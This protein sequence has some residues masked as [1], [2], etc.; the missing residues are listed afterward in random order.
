MIVLHEAL[1]T[2]HSSL[3]R[4]FFFLLSQDTYS[5][6]SILQERIAVIVIV[7]LR[8]T[9]NFLSSE[10]RLLRDDYIDVSLFA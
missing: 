5:R 9:Y 8:D 2:D 7:C 1:Y 4:V 6:T 3:P 10:L